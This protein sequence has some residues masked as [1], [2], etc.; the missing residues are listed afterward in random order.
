MLANLG[1]LMAQFQIICIAI[2]RCFDVWLDAHVADQFSTAS[3]G[4]WLLPSKKF[5]VM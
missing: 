4:S 5:M 2:R 1:A 3:L